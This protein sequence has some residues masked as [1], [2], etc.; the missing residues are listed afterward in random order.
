MFLLFM[1]FHFLDFT[2]FTVLHSIQ[3]GPYSS[4]K[5]MLHLFPH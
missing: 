1:Y 2:V 4:V 5:L 3:V